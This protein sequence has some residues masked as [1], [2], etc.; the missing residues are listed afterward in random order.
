[1]VIRKRRKLLTFVHLLSSLQGVLLLV[2]P[3]LFSRSLAPYL[4]FEENEFR[5]SLEEIELLV[6]S[7]SDRR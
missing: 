4:G 5:D 7:I 1:M 6:L 3:R 2:S